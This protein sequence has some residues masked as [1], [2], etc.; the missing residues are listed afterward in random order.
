MQ[1][2]NAMPATVLAPPGGAPV[3]LSP[4]DSVKTR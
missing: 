4:P 2:D 3:R 1:L